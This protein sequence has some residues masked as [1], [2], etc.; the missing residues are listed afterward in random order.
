MTETIRV[1][2]SAA[3]RL[4]V[5]ASTSRLYP[6]GWTGDV[7]EATARG[8]IAD[9]KAVHVLPAT[10]ALTVAQTVVLAAAADEIIKQAQQPVGEPAPIVLDDL[11]LAELKQ[12]AESVGLFYPAKITKPKL[13]EALTAHAVVMPDAV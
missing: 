2:L 12:V 6:A 5:N 4:Q 13:I 7:D 1:R 11:T 3:C 8:W 10:A 9:G